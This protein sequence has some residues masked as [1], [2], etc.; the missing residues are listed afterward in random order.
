MASLQTDPSGN[1]HVC[2][3]LGGK[4]FK[5]SLHTTAEDQANNQLALLEENLR[6]VNRGKLAI[7]DGADVPTFLLSDGKINQPVQLPENLTLGQLIQ[8][9]ED[10]L[11]KGAIEES[12]R[13]VGQPFD[14][15]IGVMGRQLHH[16][17]GFEF[18]RHAAEQPDRL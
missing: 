11:P 12:K 9:Y 6:L 13:V 8:Q 2:F 5:R 18:R 14:G 3:R 10:S 7:P 1:Y 17:R 15:G 16:H 4:R